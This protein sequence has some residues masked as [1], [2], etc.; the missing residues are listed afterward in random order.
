MI[1]HCPEAQRESCLLPPAE[2]LHC[3]FG[4]VKVEPGFVYSC[5][6]RR[7][8]GRE[9][10]GL[11]DLSW[12]KKVCFVL[13]FHYWKHY[14]KIVPSARGEWVVIPCCERN[15]TGC[16]LALNPGTHTFISVDLFSETLLNGC[17]D[18]RIRGNSWNGSIYFY[19]WITNVQSQ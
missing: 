9:L 2:R 18:S 15:I 6:L 13:F 7:E 19:S 5:L 12:R 16:P 11:C 8:E 10:N 1:V 3:L 4:L 14:W 17:S